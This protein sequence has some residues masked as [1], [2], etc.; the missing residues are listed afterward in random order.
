MKII[1]K[2]FTKRKKERKKKNQG[3][4]SYSKGWEMNDFVERLS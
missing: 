4:G 1:D 2:S 3:D